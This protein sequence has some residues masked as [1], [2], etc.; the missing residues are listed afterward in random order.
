MFEDYA[1]WA[2]NKILVDKASDDLINPQEYL[3]ELK[4]NG[5]ELARTTIEM[6]L[7]EFYNKREVRVL[8]SKLL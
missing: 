8:T 1:L 4:G 2:W 5:V 7:G 3:R 6:F